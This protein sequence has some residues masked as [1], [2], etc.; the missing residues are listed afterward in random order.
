MYR[1]A[2]IGLGFVGLSYIASFSSRGI[3]CLGIDIDKDKIESLNKGLVPVDEPGLPQLIS[4]SIDKGLIKFTNRYT[5]IRRFRP[6]YIFVSVDTPTVKSGQSLKSIKSV[7][8][9]LAHLLKDLRN[10][11]LIVVKSTILP[12]TSRNI[13]FP[14][15][16]RYSG[17]K[18][19]EI[20]Y[21]YNPEFLREGTAL[22]LSLIHI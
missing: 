13:L 1:V 16:E 18:I 12:G 7:M 5:P 4:V 21:V 22:Y 8:I 10:I 17:L 9:K 20:G 3:E 2:V 15:F 11:P 14:I 6:D 19:E